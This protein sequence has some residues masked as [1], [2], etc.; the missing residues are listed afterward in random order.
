MTQK[1]SNLKF[2]VGDIV[3]ISGEYKEF[4]SLDIN[5]PQIQ[6]YYVMSI[7]EDGT[8]TLEGV[9]SDIPAKYIESVS[10]EGNL[11][12]QI[13][14]DTNHAR[15]YEVGKVHLLE[16]IYSRPHFMVTMQE[17]FLGTEMWAELQAEGFMFVHELQHWLVERYGYSRIRINQFWGM[18]KPVIV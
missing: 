3:T 13:Y 16:D 4:A 10:I 6:V 14:Y 17:R 15:A 7:N 11:S 2:N 12:M 1:K 8:I 5:Q 18:R 9:W